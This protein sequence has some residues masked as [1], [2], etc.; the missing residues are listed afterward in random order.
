MEELLKLAP[1]ETAKVIEQNI[2]LL[3]YGVIGEKNVAYELKNSHMPILILHDL[4]LEHKDLTAQIDYVVIDQRF[5]LVIECNNMVG[6]MEIT[7]SGNF[8]RY[9]K[10]ANG[11]VYKKR[12]CIVQ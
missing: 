2:K 10:S 6:D 11:K 7:S 5:I 8:I 1:K 3:S 12:A 4:Y 9:F